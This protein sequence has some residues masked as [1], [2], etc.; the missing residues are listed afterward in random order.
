VSAPDRRQDLP[1]GTVTLLFADVEGSTKL[2]SALGERFGPARA[3]MRELVRDAARAHGGAEVDWAGDGV[4]LAFGRAHDG[5][6][7]AAQIQRSLAAEPWPDESRTAYGSESTRRTDLGYEDT[8]GWTSRSLRVSAPPRRRAIGRLPCRTWPA[9][10]PFPAPPF[11]LGGIDWGHP[12]RA[13][14]F[15]LARPSWRRFPPE[16]VVGGGLPALLPARR[17]SRRACAAPKSSSPP[18]R[19][20]SRSPARVEPGRAGSRSSGGRRRDRTSV[21]RSLPGRGVRAGAGAIGRALV[22]RPAEER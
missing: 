19:D 3:R 22:A 20:S 11:A 7:A 15:Q 14:L 2:L 1:S 6:A 9:T 12:R 8:S 4:F 17:A 16:D 13:A 18:T 5:I 10:S 21:H